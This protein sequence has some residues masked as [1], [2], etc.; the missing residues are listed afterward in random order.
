MNPCEAVMLTVWVGTGPQE[1]D[2][3]SSAV[4]THYRALNA[5]VGLLGQG[6]TS[7]MLNAVDDETLLIW[8]GQELSGRG[9]HVKMVASI[10][11]AMESGL[12]VRRDTGNGGDVGEQ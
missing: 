1:G 6:E 9:D 3:G 10:T 7:G 2:A 8:R 5:V 12:K 4:M 11:Q